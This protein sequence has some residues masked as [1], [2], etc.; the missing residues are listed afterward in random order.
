MGLFP[1]AVL[2]AVFVWLAVAFT[3]MMT[4]F[5]HR[6]LAARLPDDRAYYRYFFLFFVF[7]MAVPGAIISL[8]SAE[9]ARFFAA[10]G[11]KIGKG[12]LGLVLAAIGVPFAVL[13]AVIGSRDPVM[14]AYYP[15]SKR[16]CASAGKLAAFEAAYVFL[17]YLPWEFLFR[18][19]IFFPLVTG[20]GLVPALAIQTALSTLYHIGH[21]D[22]EVFAALGAGFVFGLVAYATGSLLYSLIIHAFV[23]ISLDVLLYRRIHRRTAGRA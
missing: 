8:G 2:P 15:F 21:P 4:V 13:A 19:I 10:A 23:G 9:P 11:L 3:L 1:E 12:S 16:V 7:F 14:Q 6:R 18:G 5:H 17:Y 22:T 20:L